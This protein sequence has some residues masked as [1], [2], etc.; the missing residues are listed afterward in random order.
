MRQTI[1][2]PAFLAA[3]AL[4]ACGGDRSSHGEAPAAPR[5]TRQIT[6]GDSL[7]DVGTYA[8]GAIG[9][10]GGGRFTIN[11][12]STARDPALTGK[13]WVDVLAEALGVA[14]PCAAITG[15]QGRADRGLAVPVQ[16]H[17]NCYNYAMGG[18][19]V[20]NPV[21][22]GNA[23][24]GSPLGALTMPVSDQVENHL[25][26]H[27]G[28]FDSGD[29]VFVM[30]GG[31]DALTLL[32]GVRSAA[33][34]T[35]A[36]AIVAQMATA[37]SELAAIVNRR[38]AGR[39]ATRVVVNNLPDLGTSPG[40]RPLAAPVRQLADAMVDAFNEALES[41]LRG[42]G[43]ILYVDLRTLSR[44]HALNPARYGLTNT[45]RPAC[46]INLLE[47]SSLVCTAA[48]LVAADVGRY[49]FSDDVHPTPFEH[50]LIAR[51]VAGRLAQ[52]GWLGSERVPAA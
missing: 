40:I 7:S 8:G 23:A 5:Y 31:N 34:A 29:I 32:R 9:Q 37:G 25:A 39:G 35:D 15:L 14:V 18:A 38:I 30:A 20:T 44:D 26:R 51:H 28:R 1:L 10:A 48:N 4:T 33:A 13:I 2:A 12:D 43:S 52:R 36:A 45:S 24:T 22:P 41:G 46:G 6:F 47:G 11:G 3:A 50:A 21:G 49:M 42:N 17:G 27:G 16:E 19:R